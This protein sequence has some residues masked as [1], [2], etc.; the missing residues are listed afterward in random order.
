M[1]IR[2][3]PST[4]AVPESPKKPGELAARSQKELLQERIQRKSHSIQASR[5][6]QIE[7]G[8]KTLFISLS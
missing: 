5:R 3:R 1:C 4:A 7:Q 2:D 6:N 8:L